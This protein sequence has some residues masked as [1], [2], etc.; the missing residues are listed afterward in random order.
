MSHITSSNLDVMVFEHR[1]IFKT[2][3]ILKQILRTIKIHMYYY[4]HIYVKPGP[5]KQS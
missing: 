5:Q 1:P 4:Q 2:I 3:E